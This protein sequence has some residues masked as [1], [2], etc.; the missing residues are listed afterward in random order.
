M[1]PSIFFL[2]VAGCFRTSPKPWM[3]IFWGKIISTHFSIFLWRKKKSKILTLHSWSIASGLTLLWCQIWKESAVSLLLWLKRNNSIIL[4][5]PA[6][7][8]S[9]HPHSQEDVHQSLLFYKGWHIHLK[10][11]YMHCK[12]WARHKINY[13]LC[14]WN[15]MTPSVWTLTTMSCFNYISVCRNGHKHLELRLFQTSIYWHILTG[16]WFSPPLT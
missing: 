7:D 8:W 5:N 13:L 3:Q 1:C 2:D 14:Q 11:R 15:K 9:W 16:L 10:S 4:R 6:L 12:V